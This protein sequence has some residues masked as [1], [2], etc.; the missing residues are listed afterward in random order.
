M[1]KITIYHQPTDTYYYVESLD[2]YM[3]K[4]RGYFLTYD[5]FNNIFIDNGEM[6]SQENITSQLLT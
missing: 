2:E 5:I 1:N 3:S 4:M 6:D